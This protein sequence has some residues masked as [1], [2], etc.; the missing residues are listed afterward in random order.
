MQTH[1]THHA[2]RRSRTRHQAADRRWKLR[3]GALAVLSALSLQAFADEPAQSELK[4]DTQAA[5]S[6]V[7]TLDQFVV[8][9]R[10]REEK[11][12]DVPIP[13]SA[14]SGKVLENYNAATVQDFAKFT[15]NLL[16]HAPNARQ[17]SISI[18]GVGKNTAN[19]ALEPSVGVI[20]DGVPSAFISQSWGDFTDLDHV[21]VLRGPQGTL[22][23]KNTTLGVVNVVVKPPTF[24]PDAS[25]ELLVGD[26]EALGAKAT[27]GGP[28]QDG[29]L[30][31]RAS[32]FSEKRN[33]PFEN[34][35]PDHSNETF[36]ER[37]RSG[38]RVQFLLLPT[39]DISVR[40][41]ADRQQSAELFPFGDPP[42]IGEPATFPN[43]VSRTANN[44][45]TYSSRIARPYFGGFQPIIG[46]WDHVSNVSAR[47]TRSASNG[48]SAEVNWTPQPGTTLT[49]ITAYRDS[50]FDAKNGEWVPFDI[51]R[52]GAVINQKQ[53]SQELRLNSSVGKTLDYTA[54]IYYLDSTV[55]SMDRTLYGA[56]AGAFY[57]TA[58]NYNAL[59]NTPVGKLLLQDS[60]RGLFVNTPTHPNT[61]SL[62][63]FGQVNWH[64][65]EKATLTLGLRRTDETKTNDYA[66]F[67]NTDSALLANLAATTLN[68]AGNATGGVYAGATA[69]EIAAARSIR[70]T[71]VNNLGSVNGESISEPAYA[72]LL[73]PSYKLDEDTLLYTSLGHGEKSG[74]VQFNSATLKP[75]NVAPEKVLDFE[76][77]FKT[78]LLNRRLILGA[79]L[80]E[81][82]ITDYQQNLTVVDP[83]LTAQNGVTT[84]RTYLGN[85]SGVRLRGLEADGSYAVTER[86]RLN[87]SGAYNKAIYSDF[88]NAPC[89]GDIA[90]QPGGQQQCDFT[91]RQLPFAPKFTANLGFDYRVPVAG[92]YV[93]H[94]FG[95]AAYRSSANYNAGLSD[96]GLQ[97]GY[98]LFDG[99]IGVQSRDGKWELALVGKNLTDKHYVTSIG[100]YS[101]QAAV[102]ATP[103]ERRY[104]GA[105]LRAKL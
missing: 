64:L 47:P 97:D 10:T 42:L 92:N 71:Q 65:D 26:H 24:K 74:S 55:D 37:D 29:V 21:E 82:R 80:Y 2:T 90:G 14:V 50:M 72:W 62:A 9:A 67:I 43:G 51:R 23:G 22:L 3:A 20:I 16:V 94:A 78:V 56:D 73:N 57:A 98:T 87:F 27:I 77:G 91:G 19:D 33:G 60:L 1:E 76:L 31:Y 30:A 25:A 46:D 8:R 38:G 66:K 53:V 89:P 13:V 49:S 32:F 45:L 18:R 6:N 75:Q 48:L 83:V 36:Q 34:L 104:L 81:T 7:E 102:T 79:N 84:Y 96:L 44:G 28:I 40:V 4:A 99:G 41:S 12:Q 69:A 93:L 88:A 86:F 95:N 52:Y 11:L 59:R 63:E 85:V 54:G 58:A 101:T 35:A 5:D 68:A 39:S 70:A 103:G 61:R 100:A 17:T 105:V 15:P